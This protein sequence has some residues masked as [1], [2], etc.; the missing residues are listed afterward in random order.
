MNIIFGTSTAEELSN[1]HAVLELD[2]ITIG[3]STPIIA[4]CVIQNI[5]L[6]ELPVTEDLKKLHSSLMENY[7]TKNWE[8]C[9]Q[10]LEQLIGKWS[11][12]MDT[13]YADLLKRINNF[14]DQDPGPGWTGIVAK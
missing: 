9:E 2:T 4:Y 13:F 12:E 7:F 11:G 1:K 10:A 8:F 14:K 6:E 5:P 3:N